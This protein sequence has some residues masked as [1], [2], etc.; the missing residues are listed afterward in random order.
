[1]LDTSGELFIINL[2]LEMGS[3]IDFLLADAWSSLSELLWD[4]FMGD[5]A[6][7]AAAR[8]KRNSSCF[9][10]WRRRFLLLCRSV[11]APLQRC[12]TVIAICWA[13]D[14]ENIKCRYEIFEPPKYVVRFM[15]FL[16]ACF[17]VQF[18]NLSLFDKCQHENFKL[19]RQLFILSSGGALLAFRRHRRSRKR[20]SEVCNGGDVPAT[21]NNTGCDPRARLL[22]RRFHC[23]FVRDVATRRKY[24]ISYWSGCIS[25]DPR[26]AHGAFASDRRFIV[27]ALDPSPPHR[28][29][30]WVWNRA[31][32]CARPT[33]RPCGRRAAR[34]RSS[35]T[36]ARAR[37]AA[38]DQRGPPSS[39]ASSPAM[40]VESRSVAWKNP[41]V[42]LP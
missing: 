38:G 36:T 42:Q 35:A 30:R 6:A 14:H 11:R 3:E 5:A 15:F 2:T 4:I 18:R 24:K 12:W 27:F 9:E 29:C 16:N 8:D 10:L 7:A 13:G 22:P 25:G 19:S 20:H 17:N 21:I 31:V 37:A 23:C 34:G 39:P 40:A 28:R 41:S 1:M 33:P 32:P 26:F